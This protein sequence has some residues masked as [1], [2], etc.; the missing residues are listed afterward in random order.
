MTTEPSSPVTGIRSRWHEV[1]ADT[2]SDAMVT[3][4]ALAGVE[5]IWFVSGTELAH[6]Q[7]AT[8]KA[9]VLGRASPKLMTM[10]HENAA[11]AAACGETAVTG[12]PSVAVFHV[13]NGLLNAGAAIHNADRGHY[14]VLM[15]SGY[16]PSAEP[17]SV[18]GA[19]DSFIQWF[20]QVPDQGAIVRQYTRWDHKLA[21]YDNPGLVITRAFQV[22]LS[23]PQGPAYL[24]VPREVAMTPLGGTVRFPTLSELR[25]AT[26]PAPDAGEL[27]EAARCLLQAQNPVIIASKAGRHPTAMACLAELAETL[28]APVMAEPFRLNLPD[29][30]PLYRGTPNGGQLP[31]KCDCALVIDTVVPWMPGKTEPEPDAKIIRIDLDPVERMTPIYDFPCDLA[32]T[33]DSAKAIPALLEEVRSQMTAE[34]RRTCEERLARLE[35]EGRERLARV[36][37]GAYRDAESGKVT[38]RWVSFQMGE[39]IPPEARI[40]HEMTDPSLFNRSLPGTLLGTGGSSI[41]WS[42]PAAVGGKAATPD[43]PVVAAVG[44]GAWMFSNPQ[45]VLWASRFHKAPVVFLVMNNRGY[46]TGT[47]TL[48]QQHPGGYAVKANDFNGGWFD[49]TPEFAAEAAASGAHGEKVTDPEEVAPALQR[50]LEAAEKQGVPAV[51]EFWLPKLVTGEV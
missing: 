51:V 40:Y 31:P 28:G 41:G 13:D 35:Q 16:P 45:V 8:T 2:V 3:A 23:E 37:E 29:R 48:V 12:K 4:M 47:D 42:A 39:V 6:F 22:A 30:H 21:S 44:D 17:G 1:P 34:Q 38:P 5:R 15:I 14:P 46:R 26:S 49:P 25:P 24:A 10:T 33:A 11:L 7:E 20:Q 50:G 43:R 9:R 36:R 32:I 18:P 19:R 27:R